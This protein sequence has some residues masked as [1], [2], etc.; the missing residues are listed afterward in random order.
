MPA[1]ALSRSQVPMALT[2]QAPTREVSLAEF[3][4]LVG[5]TR[6]PVSCALYVIDAIAKAISTA[7]QSGKVHGRLEPSLILLAADG[8]VRVDFPRAGSDGARLVPA[9]S[10]PELTADE[11]PDVLAD[12][13]AI[14]AIAYELLTGRLVPSGQAQ[15]P[16]AFNPGV[17]PTG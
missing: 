14:G 17:D 11:R 13:F 12:I 3:L 1:T 7:H 15:P 4:L 5:D 6:L 2:A 16:S 9:Y 10:A 8:G